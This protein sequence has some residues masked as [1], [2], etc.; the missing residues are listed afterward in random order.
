VLLATAFFLVAGCDDDAAVVSFECVAE[1]GAEGSSG[2]LAVDVGWTEDGGDDEGDEGG[3]EGLTPGYAADGPYDAQRGFGW[4]GQGEASRKDSWFVDFF[5]VGTHGP[6]NPWSDHA[7][8][9]AAVQPYRTYAYGLSGY[10]VDVA[11]GL[12]RVTLMFLEPTFPEPGLRVFDVESGGLVLVDGLD[13]AAEVGQ[14]QI[15]DVVLH[16]Q[17]RDGRIELQFMPRTEAPPVLAG[18]RV[19]PIS[20]ASPAAPTGLELRSGAGEALLRWDR[21]NDPVRGWWVERSEAGAGFEPVADDLTLVPSLVDRGRTPGET[22]SYRITPVAPDCTLG[23]SAESPVVTVSAPDSF[24]LPVIDVTVDEAEF[25]AIH[26]S[27]MDDV[28]VSAAVSS[29]AEQASGILR[30]RGQST[31][32]VPKRSFYL[33]LDDGTLDGRDRLKLLAEQNPPGRLLQLAAFDLFDRMGGVASTAR[34]VLLRINGRVYGVYDDIEHVGDDFLTDRGY[35]VDDRFRAGY[36]DWS[37]TYDDQ[38]QVNLEGFEKKENEGDPS[39]ELE[40]LL[41]WL[42]TAPEHQFDAELDVYLDVDA[43]V[44]YMAGQILV[45]NPEIIDGAHYLILDPADGTFLMVPWD[46]NNDT[47][48]QSEQ[49]LARNSAFTTPVDWQLWLWTRLLSNPTFRGRLVERLDRALADEFG[50]PTQDAIAAFDQEITPALAAEPFLFT[51]RYEAW[52]A[53]A[54]PLMDTFVDERSEFVAGGLA[55]LEDLGETGLVIVGIAPAE[56]RI[57]LEN[58]SE[59]EVALEGCHLSDQLHDLAVISLAEYGGIEPGQGLAVITDLPSAAG[60]YLVLSCGGEGDEGDEGDGRDE[61]WEEWG[62]SVTSL[63]FYPSLAD[64]QVYTREG[65][66]WSVQ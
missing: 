21:P 47:W 61:G 52:V 43:M 63:V 9:Q 29:E 37:L 49:S 50:A 22:L 4:L 39:P 20:S 54:P 10:R 36:V 66:G 64:G 17:A 12:Y 5:P 28:E 6:E 18:L 44:D 53:S 46:L 60:G 16:V 2:A 27:P 34:A 24:G 30:L 8:Y 1:T 58:R 62:A 57:D 41:V 38:G 19:E 35:G 15:A 45:A 32:W 40:A 25:A 14:D 56:G 48:S 59:G 55:G 65:S 31:R 51:R 42:N 26:L 7:G 23:A 11:D 33:K 3:W 13:L